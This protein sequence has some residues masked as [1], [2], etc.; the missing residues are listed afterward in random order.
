MT[1]ARACFANF[2]RC[3]QRS[4]EFVSA[5][6]ATLPLTYSL[7]LQV[8]KTIVHADGDLEELTNFPR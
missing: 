6:L 4:P 3:S 5:L 2:Q 8:H 7:L 1:S